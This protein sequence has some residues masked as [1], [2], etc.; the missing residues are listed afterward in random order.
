MCCVVLCCNVQIEAE[1]KEEAE[2]VLW[3]RKEWTASVRATN[4]KRREKGEKVVKSRPYQ[5]R[6]GDEVS[7]V[8]IRSS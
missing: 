7:K 3:S 4:K 5:A 1:N 2:G 6:N 8:V